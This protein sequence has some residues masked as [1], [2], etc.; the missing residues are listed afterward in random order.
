MSCKEYIQC[1]EKMTRRQK[2]AMFDLYI[3]GINYD[4]HVWVTFGDVEYAVAMLLADMRGD[5]DESKN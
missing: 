4:G 5:E 1:Y 2:D 3:K